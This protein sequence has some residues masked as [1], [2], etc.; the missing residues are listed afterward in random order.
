M[1]HVCSSVIAI[2]CMFPIVVLAGCSSDPEPSPDPPSLTASSDEH[3]RDEGGDEEGEESGTEYALNQ[4]YDEV[5]NGARLVLTYD[6]PSNSFNGTVQN[7]TEETLE[8]VR[9][10]VHLSNGR[11][12]GP[13]T[14]VD[15]AAGETQAVTLTATSAGFD[16]WTAH[17]EVGGGEEGHG[18][19]GHDEAEGEHRD[20]R[21]DSE[22]HR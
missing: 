11:E 1:R 12:L 3:A 14:P 18:D 17:P 10:E 16:G 20:G 2:A 9:V 4:H 7:T 6:A 21:E 13:T 19:G 5:R 22:E 15:L 8:R